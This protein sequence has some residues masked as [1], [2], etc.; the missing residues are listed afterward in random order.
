MICERENPLHFLKIF[1][2]KTKL[3]V[4]TNYLYM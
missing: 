1:L 4:K 3:F 2:Q